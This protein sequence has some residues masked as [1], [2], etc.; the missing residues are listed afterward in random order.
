MNLKPCPFCGGDA[1]IYTEESGLSAELVCGG[2]GVMFRSSNR[3]SLPR[4]WNAR[5]ARPEELSATHTDHPQQHWDRTCPACVAEEAADPQTPGSWEERCAMLYQVIGC[6]ADTAGLFTTSDDVSNALDVACG[7]GDVEN[8]LPWPSDTK[9]FQDAA[10]KL[11]FVEWLRGVSPIS[12]K[13][14]W[15]QFQDSLTRSPQGSTK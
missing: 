14:Y 9:L 7:R 15:D 2:C 8:L 3:E 10:H 11:Q 6:L 5:I 13:T 4:H 1:E 12:F